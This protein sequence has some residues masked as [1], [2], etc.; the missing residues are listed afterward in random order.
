M[1]KKDPIYSILK[2]REAWLRC[3]EIVSTDNFHVR[4]CNIKISCNRWHYLLLSWIAL[5]IIY[6]SVE[7]AVTFL[8][9]KNTFHCS[10]HTPQLVR[11]HSS[12]HSREDV[13]FTNSKAWLTPTDL[14][15]TRNNQ[16]LDGTICHTTC[17]NFSVD[18][19]AMDKGM[20]R[21]WNK[22]VRDVSRWNTSLYC[23]IKEVWRWNY[24]ET[25][26]GH[27]NWKIR[28]YAV[29]LHGTSHKAEVGY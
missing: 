8:I 25:F 23:V 22:L 1:L 28:D 10:N 15:P 12:L 7:T 19:V 29:Y 13:R 16:R 14:A 3:W 18:F 5:T 9:T 2:E 20:F 21:N 11:L 4:Y 6:H 27:Y 24:F 17:L 26:R